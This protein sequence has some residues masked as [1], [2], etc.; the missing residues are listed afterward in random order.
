MLKRS[1]INDKIVGIYKNY[2]ISF[3]NKILNISHREKCDENKETEWEF[4]VWDEKRK[5]KKI[6]QT[7]YYLFN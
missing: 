6:E 3:I 5:R 2:Y 4:E 7:C 1:I